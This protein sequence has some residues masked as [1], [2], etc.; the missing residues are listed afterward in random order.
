MSTNAS[1]AVPLSKEEKLRRAQEAYRKY[2]SQCFWFA[3]EDMEVSAEMLPFV[4]KELRLHGGHR[5][6]KLA[7][8][9]CR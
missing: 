7:H 6:W 9:L 5:G 1:S 4:I 3:P 8:E 2:H